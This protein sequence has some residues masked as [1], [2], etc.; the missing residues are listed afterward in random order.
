[1]D[2]PSPG[3]L[4]HRGHQVLGG[5]AGGCR[6]GGQAGRERGR[7]GLLAR[8]LRGCGTLARFWWTEKDGKARPSNPIPKY[9][10]E[11]LL[12]VGARPSCPRWEGAGL[13]GVVGRAAP[14][15][16]GAHAPRTRPPPARASDASPP[17]DCGALGRLVHGGGL[18]GWREQR[19]RV[20]RASGGGKGG[21][22]GV[23]G[24]SGSVPA[25]GPG[26][27]PDICPRARPSPPVFTLRN[28][29]SDA[30]SPSRTPAASR[31]RQRHHARPRRRAG[32]RRRL[33][34]RCPDESR[35]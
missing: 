19:G 11:R 18:N 13:A 21:I 17:S 7:M 31:T 3:S 8:R 9:N 26:F 2:E 29:H 10:A 12:L 35:A 32:P 6:S 16:L 34:R 20:R 33:R 23:R 15:L 28:P 30:E 1:M 5:Q 22:H 14:R 25:W 4:Y 24:S 27:S